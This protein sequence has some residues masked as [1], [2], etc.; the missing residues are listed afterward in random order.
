[1]KKNEI[2]T[3]LLA[4]GS[5]RIPKVKEIIRKYFG[6][7]PSQDINPD[8][9]V[10]IGAAIYAASL[11]GENAIVRDITPMALG[12]SAV[13]GGEHDRFSEI[14]PKFSRI[15]LSRSERFWTNYDSQ[16]EANISIYE[17]DNTH[18]KD[19]HK[20]GEFFLKGLKPAPAGETQIDVTL[21]IG[22]DGI[23]K[24]SAAEL[25]P[26]GKKG[27]LTIAVNRSLL[28]PAEKIRDMIDPDDYVQ[29]INRKRGY[30][31]L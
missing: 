20:L 5:S 14:I 30:G 21:E 26:N 13:I 2:D 28:I 15:P 8:E 27:E 10:C 7:E 12:I 3:I 11:C 23:L 17:G 25:A 18:V 31:E 22:A 6:K 9:A 1:M 24:V 29:N 16:T 4:G 19:N